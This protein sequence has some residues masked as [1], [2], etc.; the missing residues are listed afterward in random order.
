MP[1]SVFFSFLTDRTDCAKQMKGSG[2]GLA[3]YRSG[4]ILV[5]IGLLCHAHTAL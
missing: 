5:C 4:D 3:S 1:S 2:G